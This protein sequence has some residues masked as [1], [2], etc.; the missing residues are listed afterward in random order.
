MARS[1]SPVLLGAVAVIAGWYLIAVV[2]I[3]AGIASALLAVAAPSAAM[4]V[5]RALRHLG[6]LVG[7]VLSYVL[8]GV[9]DL[10]VI[11]P[12]GL[13]LRA[14]RGDPL[15]TGRSRGWISRPQTRRH[16]S[17]RGF[18]REIEQDPGLNLTRRLLAG[19][20][21]AVGIFTIVILANYCVGW[22]WDEY[23]GSHDMPVAGVGAAASLDRL[24]DAPAMGAAPWAD[25]YWTEFGA[26]DYEYLPFLLSRVG[27]TA[28][29]YIDSDGGV[30]RSF[31]AA[32][33]T[34]K[35][36]FFGG[37]AL[38]GVGQRDD[39]TITSEVARLGEASRTPI[40]TV[41]FGQPGYTSWQDVLL[42]EQ[43][44]AVRPTPDLV[45]FYDGADDMAVQIEGATSRPSHYNVAGLDA[46]LNGRDSAREQAT[47]LF[48]EYR[49]TSVITRL[50]G[51]AGSLLG[52]DEEAGAGGPGLAD[53]TAD[54]RRRSVELASYLA[55]RKGVRTLFTW[56]AS[57]GV[58]GDGG[59]YRA[60]TRR[61]G[62]TVDLSGA[63][64]AH[65]SVFLDDTLTNE[66]GAGLVAMRL[67]D[68]IETRLFS[69]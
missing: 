24:R 53:R 43:Q 36:W 23:L 28:G 59:A 60:L 50:L 45:V 2:A 32:A 29:D 63:L 69:D 57:P 21:Q 31:R 18:S 15:G 44:L 67:W 37:S 27:D 38:W 62:E 51:G 68:L 65:S 46:A 5:D 12:L 1:A 48:D 54:L 13:I 30:R 39:Q 33:P 52:L 6:H 7:Q 20:P 42:F 61:P 11:V 47:D 16:D 49:D 41:N 22:V 56:Q 26:L 17:S 66:E 4:V 19:A 55:E 25:A 9:S 10:L 3:V 58:S 40:R 14:F 8:V 35:V 34:A 64:D